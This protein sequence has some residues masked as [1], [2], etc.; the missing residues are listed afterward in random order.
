SCTKTKISIWAAEVAQI[1]Q[2]E[3]ISDIVM[4][5]SAWA[6]R[7]DEKTIAQQFE[8]SSG[9]RPRKA[10]NDRIGG[11]ILMQ[12]YIRWQAKPPRRLISGEYDDNVAQ[13]ILRTKGLDAYKVYQKSFDPEK[14]E[15]NLPK[16]QVFNTCPKFIRAIENC[17]YD[18]DNPEDVAEFDGDD[19]YDGGRYLIKAAN[20][21]VKE[22]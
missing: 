1:S 3:E 16:L 17:V 11:K 12:E 13:R 18:K 5:P 21:F 2:Y 7:G 19:P 20:H 9:F 4:D 15:T 8:E 14:P 6:K 22:S 10:D